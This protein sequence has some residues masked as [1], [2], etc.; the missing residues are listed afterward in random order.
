MRQDQFDKLQQRAEQLTDIFLE[1]SDPQMWPGYDIV[2][3]GWDKQMRGDR[4]WHKKNCVATLAIV[5]R[6]AT[7]VDIARQKTAGGEDNPGAVDPEEKELEQEM[8]EAEAEA[9]QY[10]DKYL[11]DVQ[12]KAKKTAFDKRVQGK[13]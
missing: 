3:R 9:S 12:K 8:A 6:I 4:Y 7:V 1:E 5:Q 13:K 10:L 11:N 2:P